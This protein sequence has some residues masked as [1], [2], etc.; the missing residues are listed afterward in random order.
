MRAMSLG[1]A[2]L[3]AVGLDNVSM[4]DVMRVP[5]AVPTIQAAIDLASAGDIILVEPGTYVEAINFKGKRVA[6]RSV[7]G[8]KQTRI[9]RPAGPSSPTV[10]FNSG[11]SRSA[12][13][14]GF[15]VANGTGVF[16]S[17][18]PCNCDGYQLG[19]GILITAS[20]SPS[21][22]NCEIRE[23]FCGTYF[24]RG[25][26]IYIDSG[27]ALI[28]RCR[29]EHNQANGGYGR[30]G[31]VWIGGGSP[32]FDDCVVRNNSVSSYWYG[33]GGGI[34]AQGGSPTF[35]NVRIT[36]S[37][38]SHGIGALLTTPTTRLERVYIGGSNSLPVQAGEFVDL[39]GNDFDG[40][41]N[42]NGV[43]D[44]LEIFSGSAEDTDHD[45]MPDCCQAPV[46]CLRGAVQ[47]RVQDGGNGHWYSIA[48]EPI[49]T[50]WSDL[51]AAASM[52]GAH[53]LTL[54]SAAEQTF[55]YDHFGVAVLGLHADAGS[56]NFSWANGESGSFANWG[57]GQ[58]P[59]G[60][61]P[62]NPLAAERFVF[63]HHMDCV[64]TAGVKPSW[65]DYQPSEIGP[66][67]SSVGFEWD[68]D[69]NGD[70]VVDY[71]QILEG[72]LA[73]MN[74]NNVPDSCECIADSDG[75]GTPDC[76]DGCP[77]NHELSA[78]ENYFIDGDLDGFGAGSPVASCIA[79]PGR[80][81]NA[82]DC[83]DDVAAL[84]P[85]A[86]E[87][88][89]NLGVDND[90]D[91]VNGA[92]EAIDAIGYFTDAD[93]DGFGS[94]A[95]TMSC[96]D[97][98]GM[99]TNSD[100]CDDSQLL[101][102]DND[103][104]G[105]GAGVLAACGVASNVDCNDGNSLVNP[106]AIELCDGLDNNCNGIVDDGN[107]AVPATQWGVDQ[108]GN[109]HWYAVVPNA[110][111]RND[112]RAASLAR[113]GDLASISTAAENAHIFALLQEGG[114]GSAWIGGEQTPGSCEPGCGWGWS[115][116]TPWGYTSW[117]PSEP[118]DGG[119]GPTD[120]AG[121]QFILAGATGLWNDFWMW[122]SLPYVIEWSADC[123]G[124]GIVDYGQILAGELADADGNGVPDA[125]ENGASYPGA[126]VQWS[127]ASGGNGHWYERSMSL[128]NWFDAEAQAEARGG[129]LV[130][131]A[132]SGE[133][134]FVLLH[135][136]ATYDWLGGYAPPSQGC[137][138]AAWRWVTGE[139]W[140]FAPW[141]PSEPN[142]CDETALTFSYYSFRGWNNYFPVA[143][144][145]YWIEWDADCNNDG[146]VDYGQIRIGTLFD[147]N[148]NNV[149]DSCECL[150]DTDG[151][152]TP[153]CSD[154]CPLDPSQSVQTAYFADN[155]GDSFG[156]GAATMSCSAIPGSVTNSDDCDDTQW[157]F[158]DN[159]GD[160][161]GAGA[162]IACGLASN[163]DCND[164]NSAVNPNAVE[165]CDGIDNNCNGI[166]DEGA[167]GNDV[168]MAEQW[169]SMSGG[170][171]HWYALVRCGP[172]QWDEARVAAESL[173]GH[174]A[175]LTTLG[176]SAFV[177]AMLSQHGDLGESPTSQF[178]PWLGGYQ[179]DT[180]MEPAGGWSWI[181]GEPW[182]FTYWASHQPDNGCGS[183][184]AVEDYLHL[185]GHA[186]GSEW[187]MW[188]DLSTVGCGDAVVSFLV[189]WD[190]DCNHDG[191]VDFGQILAGE[192]ADANANSIPDSCESGNGSSPVATQWRIEDGGNG[193][194][195]EGVFVSWTGVTWSDA[196]ALAASK[197]GDLVS[198]NTPQ[199]RQWVFANVAN[200]PSLWS[201]RLGPW[202][203]GFQPDGSSEPN[204]EWM[205]VDGTPLYDGFYWDGAHP[206]GNDNCGGPAN[207]MTYWG[208]Y[209]DGVG[210]LFADCA[211][212]TQL[213]CWNID[214][215]PH[216]AYVAEYSA[217]CNN[218]GLVDYGQIL[219]GE[220]VDA[221]HN[222][223]PD[224]CEHSVECP[225]A[226]VEWKL[227]EG[228]NGHWYQLKSPFFV[229]WVAAEAFAER[230]GGH[231]VTLTSLE[232]QTFAAALAFSTTPQSIDDCWLGAYQ[233][234]NAPDYS[235]PAGGWRWVT[236]EPWVFTS[237][238]SDGHPSGQGDYLVATTVPADQLGWVDSHRHHEP[239]N[240]QAFVEWSA[241]CNDDG[242]V[243]YGQIRDGT[244]ADA[245]HNN[246]PDSCEC[247]ADTDG[248]GT[249]DCTDGCPLNPA[250]NAP[251]AYFADNDGDGFGAGAA[252]MSCDEIAG[253]VTNDYDCDDTQLLYADNDGDGFGAGA[254][255]ACG[256]TTNSDCDDS[257]NAINP[258]ASESCDGTDNNCNGAID[259]GV[260]GN[261]AMQI[262]EWSVSDGG[263]GHYYA[264]VKSGPI[265]WNQARV[266]AQALGGHLAT[267]TTPEE[268][269]FVATLAA[270][271]TA[272]K[273]SWLGPWLG[274]HQTPGSLEPGN[275]WYWVTGE[276]WDWTHWLP[277][278][279][280]NA[281]S[282][283]PC[284]PEDALHYFS[285]AHSGPSAGWNDAPELNPC[286][287]IISF[288][289][290]WDA[291]CNH[292]GAI[293]Y[294]Q[295]HT[296]Q[297]A[298]ANGNNTPDSCEQSIALHV[299]WVDLT[300]DDGGTPATV[301]G[302]IHTPN[303]PV[304]VT[305]HGER[306]FSY[307]DGGEANWS[308][309][310]P[311]LS[312]SVPNGPPSTDIISLVG[313][314]VATGRITFSRAVTNPVMAVV[315]LGGGG[316]ATARL[317]F[318]VPFEIL[319][320]GASRFGNGPFYKQ[321]NTLAGNEG[322]G[323]IRF[324]GT[325]TEVGFAMPV[326]EHWYGFTVGIAEGGSDCDRDGVNDYDSVTSGGVLDGNGNTV[327]DSCEHA[328]A[329]SE[330]AVQW[331]VEQGGN[332]HWY[333]G[334]FVSSAGV[335][336][337][338]ARAL[339][340]AKGGDLVSLNTPQERQWVFAN[341]ANNPS[342]WST[343]LGPWVG[344]FQLADS[345]EPAGG[346]M[347]VDG[348]PLY[349]GFFWDGAHPDGN[350]N[351]GGPANRMTYWGNY[352][353]GAGDLFADCAD[354]AQL[355]CWNI[356][357]GPHYSYVVEYSADCNNDGLVDFG[358]I[359]D[360]TLVD[361]NHNNIPDSCECTADSDGDGTPDC[362]DGCPSSPE[363]TAPIAYYADG[364]SDGFGAGAATMSCSAIAGSVGNN[365]DCDDA[366][367]MYADSDG[368]GYGAGAMI[369]CG[370][371]SSIDDCN[372]NDASV[373]P[374]AAE[375]CANLGTDNDCD[376]INSDDE[377]IDSIDY[378]VDG[379]Q[380]GF[381][382]GAPTK[383]CS[384]IPGS[385]PNADDCDDTQLT[386]A[387]ADADG[388]GSG[389]WIACGTATN[390]ADCDDSQLLYADTD[391]DGYGAGGAVACGA[392]S[393]SDCNDSD[394]SIHPSAIEYCNDTDDDCDGTVDGGACSL[395][396][397]QWSRSTGGNGHWYLA[398]DAATGLAAEAYAAAHGA[399]LATIS[400]AAEN[401]FVFQIYLGSGRQWGYLG[402][403]QAQGQATPA[404]GW[405]WTN[406][407]PVNYTNWSTHNGA[408]PTGAP[409]D[410][411]CALPPWGVEDDQADQCVMQYDG[412][413]DDIERGMPTCGSP[414]WNNTAL[415][416]FD[417]DCNND[418][419]VDYGQILAGEIADANGNNIP[420][421]CEGGSNCPGA[422]VQWRVEDGG[423]G[424]WYG[425]TEQAGTWDQAKLLARDAAGELVSIS[426]DGENEVVHRL[427]A[428]T[429]GSW[430]GASKLPQQPWTWADGSPWGYVHWC[431]GEPCCG[432]AG[433]YVYLS[434]GGCWD[435][436]NQT[437][438]LRRGVIEW[439]SDCN[440]DG[441]VDF[442]QILDG[443]LVDANHNHIPD[444]CECAGDLNNDG[445]VSSSDLSL[446]LT[447]WGG[448]TPSIADI[449]GDGEVNAADMTLL[450]AHWGVCTH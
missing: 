182:D 65:D 94:G 234:H 403:V 145:H 155:D 254:P 438:T 445:Y 43:D 343:R 265:T 128:A 405:Y 338:D 159:D 163:N 2:L 198:L 122:Q 49:A 346:W 294:G 421:C 194:W 143:M 426:N 442:G 340:I 101:F 370:G 90:C 394:S 184:G 389:P 57:T 139:P 24:S 117:P 273:D 105:F 147:V 433:L 27:E 270:D 12:V 67:L 419:I 404:D 432:D 241:D 239:G 413:W 63:M 220:L 337:T 38:A 375:V 257:N 423:N 208:N 355:T 301:A 297:L 203:G 17:A 125:C 242:I 8:P 190:A 397:T 388:F 161:F 37:T 366:F 202:V 261:D 249:P 10:T 364:D 171:G 410:S 422:P 328:P 418:G 351:C 341:V 402:F 183:T 121:L 62:N 162:P 123:T 395:P 436:H 253:S 19:G 68:A 316:G 89:G 417:A 178:G 74:H 129:H 204:G 311:Y 15:T 406:G 148:N 358:Q 111:Q 85:G 95:A 140:S 345:N 165:P 434:V 431:P 304:E 393:N 312:A 46:A 278:D 444:E 106:S 30:G 64:G 81:T 290:E 385:V 353:A 87:D 363:L 196:R 244:L 229:S 115:D 307:L 447:S 292:D 79:I 330:T 217:D 219:A 76:S 281:A 53:L 284:S 268:N 54:G 132:D 323:L 75:D 347:W 258:L 287:T 154:G 158:A 131:I 317:E 6:V 359:L 82:L 396:A 441:L 212:N 39:G 168:L 245:N 18:F 177:A 357:F 164:G 188:N 313:G 286:V 329:W 259:E 306:L 372:D 309:S 28:T 373:Y 334:V 16:Y 104:D 240:C 211:D 333:E 266:A 222:N 439:S 276:P 157:L 227:S 318:N 327:P 34:W 173:G 233:D 399:H 150:L 224:C 235:E 192:L 9:E 246:V 189:E 32:T 138:P 179:A 425:L 130:T 450:L 102:A 21:V 221:D 88:C 167:C 283:G 232:E 80:V 260:C 322:S 352:V 175:T 411:P 215:G 91:G 172:V 255:A 332:G 120:E 210:D 40:D 216:Y 195:Y 218:D 5:T 116:G 59:S 303:G 369:A 199:E 275:G 29:I 4:A 78:P 279:P 368:D 414:V 348:T 430:I 308:P 356:D 73:D 384:P 285:P 193:H 153:D 237:W 103:G 151:D 302:T 55:F 236:G 174:L 339:A 118:N 243:D 152:G 109:G 256:V 377:A 387:D 305:Y 379:D 124:D 398:V 226:A 22:S 376:G 149:S 314:G 443:T 156:A 142:Y 206:D 267:V 20:S 207:R 429:A 3:V 114:V 25:G 107:C 448:A 133:N 295:V 146:L 92:E 274:G 98:A 160:G 185:I 251:I 449:N 23:N 252:S 298:D 170:N 60:P 382:A 66:T 126:A 416:E 70:G 169:S 263:N 176:E 58:C 228:G 144:A 201:T 187:F 77:L 7:A 291:D 45:G 72:T 50:N 230:F 424:H 390:D 247:F 331:P 325:F 324:Q 440:N 269:N 11:E 56:P 420:D 209:V 108:G 186:G 225:S 349:D 214:F 344:G 36:N 135:G 113:G 127:V 110:L 361:S 365:S 336:W 272:W 35:R 14:D 378:F 271:P 435:D 319:S 437:E 141:A 119:G 44:D 354:N 321:G 401:A 93:A 360:G 415:L 374:G 392:T 99:V 83:N 383:S 409:D 41:C 200:N 400:N 134:A 26:G 408:F 96:I 205:W 280:D 197:G 250:L 231:L 296:G 282:T 69:C 315:S 136:A 181:T 446:L 97:I 166:I 277:G 71:G 293:D 288:V 52:R 1:L 428:G 391:R 33:Y 299:D 238:R 326:F 84:H 380:D 350:D 381:G 310:D 191:A 213:T 61:Y 180:S 100:D 51:N 86:L 137:N 407:E 342:L 320:N 362:I 48:S 47:W 427:V 367:V 289:V 335:T 386:F 371:V 31:G 248:D 412:R 264:L 300:S 262:A 112:A 42:G 223:I 13:L